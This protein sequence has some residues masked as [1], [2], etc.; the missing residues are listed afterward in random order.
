MGERLNHT[1]MIRVFPRRTKWTPVDEFAFVGDP[2]LF[3]PPEMPVRVSVT[4]EWDLQEGARLYDAWGSLYEDVV[5]GG[6]A[7]GDH[8][9]EFT[10]GLFLKKGVT[11]TSRG[12]P[13][14]CPWCFVPR[15][16]GNIR[17]L[18]I[19]AGYIVQDNNL[20]ACSP[21]H[22]M[23]VFEMLQEQKRNIFFNG[24]L[25][26]RLFNEHHRR[27]LDTIKIGELW[28][29]CD[30]HSALPALEKVRDLI[31]DISADKKRCFVMIGRQPETLYDAEKRLH[32]I[33]EL[34][35]LPFSQLYRGPG[36]MIYTKAWLALNKKWSRPAL[37]R[38]AA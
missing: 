14:L 10:P 17:E 5:L 18:E 13:R 34:G 4:F 27:L 15:R 29:A 25:D 31:S 20:L 38:R 30:H 24:G 6:P 26:S 8:G 12:C 37:Y 23:R 28:F 35:F 19:K 21:E 11:I 3:R 7:F 22:I 33:Y 32:K 16:E 1:E 2:P 9:G 36:E